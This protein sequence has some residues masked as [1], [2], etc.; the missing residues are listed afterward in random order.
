MRDETNKDEM[1]NE[2]NFVQVG[3]FSEPQSFTTTSAG[4]Q[5]S[6]DDIVIEEFS[7]EITLSTRLEGLDDIDELLVTRVEDNEVDIEDLGEDINRLQN[8]VIGLVVALIV[9]TLICIYNFI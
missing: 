4:G 9:L 3:E 2:A 7:K 1:R 6:P 5:I 8:Y